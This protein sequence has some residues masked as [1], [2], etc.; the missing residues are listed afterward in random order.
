MSQSGGRQSSAGMYKTRYTGVYGVLL[1]SLL[2]F[3]LCGL[4]FMGV[5]FSK[6]GLFS[7]LVYCYG[8]GFSLFLGLSFILSYVY[9]MRLSLLLL[10]GSRGLSRG[11]SRFFLTI[12]G[13]SLLGTLVNWFGSV[14]FEESFELSRL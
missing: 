13:L 1:Q 10:N 4:P 11:Y 14:I 7:R 3:S 8:F 5:F 2:V 6:H 9:S 12:V